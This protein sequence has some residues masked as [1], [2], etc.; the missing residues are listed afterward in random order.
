[1]GSSL[2]DTIFFPKVR[3]REEFGSGKG[4]M[5]LT[6]VFNPAMIHNIPEQAKRQQWLLLQTS[7]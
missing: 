1:M 7:T 6:L 3:G 2:F 4:S 5:N